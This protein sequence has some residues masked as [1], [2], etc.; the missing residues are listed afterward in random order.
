MRVEINPIEFVALVKHYF[1]NNDIKNIIEIG[2]LNAK[3]AIFFKEQFPNAN[4]YCIEALPEN[5]DA[6]IKNN[7]QI[8]PINTVITNYNGKTI[9][10]R[11][12]IN[13]IHSIL[14][15]GNQYGTDKIEL[16]CQ[17]LDTLCN[18][19]NITSPDMIKIDTEGTTYEVLQ[20]AKT[21]LPNVKI[22]HIETESYQFFENQYLH[23]D[24]ADFL[25][26]NN[27]ILLDMTSACILDNYKQ[28]DSVWL[29]RKYKK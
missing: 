9:F 20:G 2:S 15:R 26:H 24:V 13:G 28:H 1:T 18:T 7:T 29:N 27:F 12:K 3:D 10:H 21:V 17:T 19:Y 23:E 22:L 14:N 25:L 6:Y 4:V 5:Y 8:I 16:A 11:K